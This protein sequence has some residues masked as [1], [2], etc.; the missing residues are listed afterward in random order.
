MVRGQRPE[1]GWA[2]EGLR[3]A[4]GRR[5]GG[6]CDGLGF[7]FG[8]RRLVQ[9]WH[10]LLVVRS[11]DLLW[12]GPRGSVAQAGTSESNTSGVGVPCLVALFV[13][14]EG[15]KEEWDGEYEYG[16]SWW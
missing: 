13:L 2:R 6:M 14:W 3:A 1:P 4:L 16:R 8:S 11:I 7:N 12:A 15:R 5:Q 10:A 9:R